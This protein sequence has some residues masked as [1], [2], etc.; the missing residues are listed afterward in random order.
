MDS[1]CHLKV[2]TQY[3][4]IKGTV[5][6]LNSAPRCDF[7]ALRTFLASPCVNICVIYCLLLACSGAL[8]GHYFMIW[9]AKTRRYAHFWPSNFNSWTVPLSTDKYSQ[10]FSTGYQRQI[11]R[12]GYC[13]KML[14]TRYQNQYLEQGMSIKYWTHGITVK[15]EVHNIAITYWV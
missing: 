5:Q 6:L 10:I 3:V 12:I 14:S 8:W 4:H 15:Y 11:F 1:N 7:L 9:E 2:L 13:N